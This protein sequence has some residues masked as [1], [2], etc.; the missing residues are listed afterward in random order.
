MNNT[1]EAPLGARIRDA[2]ARLT[3][4]ASQFLGVTR[5]FEYGSADALINRR[6]L[7][8]GARNRIKSVEE[9]VNLPTLYEQAA[10]RG[11]NVEV[12]CGPSTYSAIVEHLREHGVTVIVHSEHVPCDF[13]LVDGRNIRIAKK[14]SHGK[15][16]MPEAFMH[17]ISPLTHANIMRDYNELRDQPQ[18]K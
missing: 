10:L 15:H 9:K 16:Q 5:N 18:S 7:F 2:A 3:F 13:D 1:V 6:L 12:I 17:K 8:E 4:E 11:V 14:A